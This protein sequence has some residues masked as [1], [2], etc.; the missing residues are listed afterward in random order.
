[1]NTFKVILTGATGFVG[2]GVLMECLLH[3]AVTE[4]LSVSRKPYELH[5]PK[6]KQ[7]IV[8]DFMNLDYA[9]DDLKGYDACFYCVGISSSGLDEKT[10]TKITYDTT[11]DFA[12]TLVKLNPDIVFNFV[13][14]KSTDS[15]EQGKVMWARVKGR[16]ENALAKMPF[17]NQY[18]FRPGFMKPSPGQGN[19]KGFYKVISPIWPLLFPSTSCKMKEVGLAMINAVLKGYSKHTLEVEDIKTLA[20]K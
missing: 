8:P 17:K 15:S 7:C 16:T 13:S 11:I 3:P 9:L 6:L 10:Y 20:K 4:V 18:N 12:Q 14:G 5:H 19:V 1:M 2:E